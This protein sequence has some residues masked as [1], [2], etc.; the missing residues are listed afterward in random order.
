MPE[1]PEV[2][3]IRQSLEPY[4]VGKRVQSVAIFQPRLRWPVAPDLAEQL[5]KAP[6]E[7][8]KRRGKY[9]LVQTG[10]GVLI[11]HLGMSGS[12]RLSSSE[13]PLRPHDHAAFTL[14]A[15]ERLIFHDPRRFGALVWTSNP[16]T[17]PLLCHLG[18]EPFD[19]LFT[20]D[21][22]WRLARGRRQ[23]VKSLLMDQRV[24][25][26][27]GNIYANEALFSAGI[28]PARPAG[29]ISKPRYQKL[30]TAV[31]GILALAIAQGGTT[32]RDFS[33]ATG[34]PG[35]FQ[36]ALQVY[37]REGKPCPRCARPIRRIALGQR[38]TYY[39]A[40]CQS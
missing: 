28:H 14:E 22:L 35:Y 11:V 29:E 20:G 19:P 18:L 5:P 23:A 10:N 24:V 1:L 3:T 25:V 30:V 9:L 39:C 34:R 38:A 33:D 26:G 2:E 37:G 36:L 16:A 6:I 15:G 40:R 13:Q 21:W 31:R 8:I 27:I 17:H 4:L 12:L 7:E 32:L